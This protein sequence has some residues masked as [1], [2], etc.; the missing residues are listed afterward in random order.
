MK[1]NKWILGL[2]ILFLLSFT[3]LQCDERKELHYHNNGEALVQF[4]G[5]EKSVIFS[6]ELML[7][8]GNYHLE[9]NYQTAIEGCRVSIAQSGNELYR[10]DLSPDSEQL[11]ADFHLEES[12]PSTLMEVCLDST[13]Y[14]EIKDI[15]VESDVPFHHNM[16]L[17]IL[18]LWVF[19]VCLYMFKRNW[20]AGAQEKM[21]DLAFVIGLALILSFVHFSSNAI[22]KADDLGYHLTRIEGIARGIK[23]GQFPVY[24]YPDMLEGN[25]YLNVLYPS[26][27]LY[28]PAV[29]RLMGVSLIVSYKAFLVII[30]IGTALSMYAAMKSISNRRAVNL[31]AVVLYLFLRYRLTNIYSRGAL[32]ETLALVFLPL[33]LAGV[34]HLSWGDRNK[35][36]MLMLGMTGVI[37]SHVLSAVL[38]VV[39]AFVIMALCMKR[40]LKEKRYK[41]IIIS[42]MGVCI[43]NVGFGIPFLLYYY[44]NNLQL[45]TLTQTYTDFAVNFTHLFGI[46]DQYTGE[47]IRDYS[48]GFPIVLLLGI[49]I[50]YSLI[51]KRRDMGLQYLWYIGL[52]LIYMSSGLFPYQWI[53]KCKILDIVFSFFQFPFRFIGVA[54]AIII[55][56]G[57][58][59]IAEFDYL[60]KYVK[61][62]AVALIFY[63]I[64]DTTM[65]NLQLPEM[66]YKYQ[67]VKTSGGNIAL[68]N[69]GNGFRYWGSEDID[70]ESYPS[71]YLPEGCDQVIKDYILSSDQ[72][73]EIKSYEKHQLDV[74]LQYCAQMQDT[75]LWIDIPLLHYRGYKA[76]DENGEKIELTTGDFGNIRILLQQDEKMHN[77]R[78]KFSEPFICRMA[79]IISLLGTAGLF[80]MWRYSRKTRHSQTCWSEELTAHN[81]TET[82]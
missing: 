16:R 21:L 49:S 25:G 80:L 29:L 5:E 47:N 73:I 63:T 36:W 78:I 6:K 26:L 55:M 72:G 23:A 31:L 51:G 45:E 14:I 35:W 12:V 3:L 79:E 32:G 8:R 50:L 1:H 11:E 52:L 57:S 9:I 68:T 30:N 70:Y 18:A 74:E 61:P 66:L 58:I 33:V 24:V 15:Y 75:D 13:G 54:S 48:L 34:Y 20:E 44:K 60:K 7:E 2:S 77:I 19:A 39:I 27:F 76:V 10:Y 71:E 28:F 43:L 17:A 59:W 64:I 38:Y 56:V 4:Y 40:I 37:N 53:S 62:I 82:I 69:S 22:Y 67:D 81:A 41:E 42:C 46:L 65:W